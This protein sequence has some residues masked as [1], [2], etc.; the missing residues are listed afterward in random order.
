SAG[1]FTVNNRYLAITN[2]ITLR[3]AGPS[4][5]VL[6]KT[7]GAFPGSD[8][9]TDAQP[10]VVI[11]PNRWPQVDGS[12]SQNLTADGAQGAFSATVA[13]G[14]GFAPGQFVLLDEDDYLTGAWISLPKRSGQATST[15]IWAT[16][17]VV[18]QRHDP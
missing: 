9:A 11:G 18:W 5:T 2:G 1:T 14:A 6:Q 8:V 10:I 17:R 4:A 7:N 12:T 13:S 3:G 15:R 16:D